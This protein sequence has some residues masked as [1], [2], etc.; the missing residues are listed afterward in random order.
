MKQKSKSTEILDRVV[1]FLIIASIVGIVAETHDISDNAR[2]LLGLFETVTYIAFS[3]EYIYR[4][5]QARKGLGVQSYAL[6]FFGIIDLLAILPFFLPFII[7]VDARAIRVLRLLRLVNVI[8]IGRH[9]RAI[10]TL[11]KVIRSVRTEV[12]VTLFASIVVVV[13]AGILMYYAEHQTQPEVFTNMSQSIW[14]AVA[15]LTTIGY[16]D[17][18]PVTALGKIIASSL[19]FVGVGLVAIPA[20][21]ISAAYVDEINSQKK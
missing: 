9:N 16:G 3:I 8:K 20:G 5:L 7:A 19:A 18:Y 13:F 15:T 2:Y 11:I 12:A 6:S 10:N 1:Y 21:L 14:W 17:I 4:I